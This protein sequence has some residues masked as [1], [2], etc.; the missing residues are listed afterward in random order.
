MLQQ[1]KIIKYPIKVAKDHLQFSEDGPFFQMANDVFF[2]Y[3]FTFLSIYYSNYFATPS[4][5]F[6]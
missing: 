2:I 5:F 6:G 3:N 4:T 1:V